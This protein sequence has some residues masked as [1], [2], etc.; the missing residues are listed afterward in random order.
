MKSSHALANST[1]ASAEIMRTSSSAFMI[2][3]IRASGS[4]W[5]LKSDA[6]AR[7]ASCRWYA[8]NACSCACCCWSR[9]WCGTA[10]GPP[11]PGTPGTG[12]PAPAAAG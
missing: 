5:F 7:S 8:Q 10:G 3:L 6:D 9:W 4:W 12:A 2:F 11:A 1:G